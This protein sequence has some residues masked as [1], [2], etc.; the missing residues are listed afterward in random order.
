MFTT[1]SRSSRVLDGLIRPAWDAGRAIV[2]GRFRGFIVKLPAVSTDLG[3][4]GFIGM[5]IHVRHRQSVAA[6]SV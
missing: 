2:S 1:G 5:R 6:S 4:G 3:P